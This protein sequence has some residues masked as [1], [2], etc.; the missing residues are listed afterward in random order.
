[1]SNP[2]QF[3]LISLGSN[4]D[5]LWGDPRQTVQKAMF[6]V[7]ELSEKPADLSALYATPAF[8][9]GAGP[10]FVNAAMVLFTKLSAP[11]LLTR[12][13][14]IEA[15]AGRK[16]NRRWGQRTLDLDL[17]ALGDTVLPDPKTQAGWRSLSPQDQQTMTPNEIILPHPRLQD[18]AFVLVPMLDVA[19]NWV[20]PLLGRSITQLCA[21]L[22]DGARAEVVRLGDAHEP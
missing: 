6:A 16:R 9:A 5:S 7:G 15:A 11:D 22:Q 17:I 14:E 10:D 19:A 18:R 20:H 13:H 1:M 2:S 12:L 8:P 3:A 21:D 4:E